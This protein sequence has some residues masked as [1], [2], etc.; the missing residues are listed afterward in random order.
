MGKKVHKFAKHMLDAGMPMKA[1]SEL[2][3][4]YV[5]QDFSDVV[6]LKIQADPYVE[7]TFALRIVKKHEIY[8][9]RDNEEKKLE[10]MDDLDLLWNHGA[11]DEVEF[12]TWPP[13]ANGN[14]LQFFL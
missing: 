9:R 4:L 14:N 11:Y 8:Y 3:D 1:V 5:D 7:G 10:Y 6:E 13:I 12:N 2:T